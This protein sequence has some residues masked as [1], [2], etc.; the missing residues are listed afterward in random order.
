M[1]ACMCSLHDIHVDMHITLANDEE[2]VQKAFIVALKRAH[3]TSPEQ[4]ALIS[5]TSI[6]VCIIYGHNVAT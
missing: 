4:V 3:E 6:G 1:H 2:F 5:F